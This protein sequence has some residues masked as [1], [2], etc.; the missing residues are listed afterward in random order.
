MQ[1]GD[2]LCAGRENG[3]KEMRSR[4]EKE[5]EVRVQW[6]RRQGLNEGEEGIGR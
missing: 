1:L 3:T 6:G 2:R 5:K 4:V